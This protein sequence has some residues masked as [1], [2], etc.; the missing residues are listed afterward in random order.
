VTSP[1]RF[2]ANVHASLKCGGRAFITFP[3]E[4]EGSGHGVTSFGTYEDLAEAVA[5]AGFLPGDVRISTCE[6]TEWASRLL[7]LAWLKPRRWAKK[8]IRRIWPRTAPP[9][10]FDETDFHR[11]AGVLNPLAPII[12]AYCWAVM[13]LMSASKPA[14]RLM[15][16]GKHIVDC[17]IVI[18]AQ[19]SRMDAA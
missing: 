18:Q 13:K 19:R 15:P 14:Y 1:K 2:L 3:N 4:R 7:Q 8:V 12:N 6:L 9:Q 5:A 10:V 16:L 11:S 17:Q